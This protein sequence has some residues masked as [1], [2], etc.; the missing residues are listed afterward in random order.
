MPNKLEEELKKTEITDADIQHAMVPAEPSIMQ[1]IDYCVRNQGSIEVM[2]KLVA[3]RDRDRA[4]AAKRAFDEA[5]EAAQKAVRVVVPDLVNE[6]TGK[7]YASYKALDAA[8]RPIYVANNLS[9][10]FNAAPS[11]NPDEIYVLCDVSHGGHTKTYTMPMSTDG[12]GPKGGGVMSKQQAAVAATSYGRSTL[13]RLIFNIPIGEEEAGGLE[14][15]DERIEFIGQF[16][17]PKELQKYFKAAAA[18]AFNL[19]DFPAMKRLTQAKNE[20]MAILERQ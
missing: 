16:T 19:N 6:Q 12:K 3:M 13:L 5:M 20:R 8:L 18:E 11:P 17:D 10:S 14:D 2:E 7:K 1:M 4:Y 15:I 9:L